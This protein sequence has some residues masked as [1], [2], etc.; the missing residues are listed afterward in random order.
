MK[1][2]SAA[3]PATYRGSR[4]GLELIVSAQSLAAQAHRGQKRADGNDYIEHPIEVVRNLVNVGLSSPVQLAAAY[5]HDAVEKGAPATR[6]LILVELGE[7]VVQLVDALTDDQ[8]LPSESRRHQQLD[9]AASMPLAAKQ[10]KLADRLANLR[11]PRPDWS[12]SKRQRYAHQSSALLDVLAGSH[13][14]LEA[15]VRQRLVAP[16][17]ADNSLL[18]KILS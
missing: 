16:E 3:I 4:S 5:L 2:A 12:L 10:I 13:A 6:S 17:W 15:Q 14:A 18:K 11:A 9:R 8:Q 7:A 1:S